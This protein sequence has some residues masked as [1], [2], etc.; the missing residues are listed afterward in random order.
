MYI[1]AA[2][3]SLYTERTR[4]DELFTFKENILNNGNLDT[5]RY[6][7]ERGSPSVCL[8]GGGM[9]YIMPEITAV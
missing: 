3:Q 9:P 7:K 5:L 4:G 8:C 1:G 2:G 6:L